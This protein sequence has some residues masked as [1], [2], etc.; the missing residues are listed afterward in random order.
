MRKRGKEIAKL[1]ATMARLAREERLEQRHQVHRLSGEYQGYGE[2]QIER[3]RLL[4]WYETGTEI[5]F[6]RTGTHSDLF[7]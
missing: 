4:I 6:V 7:G 5:V 2:C 1:D 3:D